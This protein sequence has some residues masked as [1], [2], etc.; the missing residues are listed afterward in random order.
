MSSVD[1]GHR[2][3][4]IRRELERLGR[5]RWLEP[6]ASLESLDE[7]ARAWLSDR[8]DEL[9]AALTPWSEGDELPSVLALRTTRSMHEAERTWHEAWERIRVASPG[10]I[11][12]AFE[13]ANA[14]LSTALS[15]RARSKRRAMEEFAMSTVGRVRARLD[16]LAVRLREGATFVPALVDEKLGALVTRHLEWVLVH[17]DARPSPFGPLLAIWLRGAWPV[18]LPGDEA[19]IY[20]PIEHEGSVVP[21]IEGDPLNRRSENPL[22]ERHGPLRRP[23]GA[24]FT[25]AAPTWWELGLSFPLTFEVKRFRVGSYDDDVIVAG[26]LLRV[27]DDP[28]ED[29]GSD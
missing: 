15:T 6:D 24:E 20:V 12:R 1:L 28:T 13:R 9:L 11:L 2:E 18:L 3:A 8:L 7:P 4:V 25:T 16:T 27:G 21:W 19:V 17:G 26:M 23:V 29:P 22:I 5:G 10:A 14:A